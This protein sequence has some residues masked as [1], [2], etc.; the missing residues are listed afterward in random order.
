MFCLNFQLKSTE[1]H[2][3]GALAEQLRMYCIEQVKSMQACAK[4]FLNSSESPDRHIEMT[5]EMAHPILWTVDQNLLYWPAKCL[6]VNDSKAIV[7]FFGN[8]KT[9]TVDVKDCWLYSREPPT[10][11]SD[12][13]QL[14]ARNFS[15]ALEVRVEANE[16]ANSGGLRLNLIIKIH[17][18]G[19][20]WRKM[21]KID[22]K[23]R[24][25]FH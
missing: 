16:S 3:M 24:F 25:S 15:K 18:L 7:Q 20:C 8:H 6:A 1:D 14:D 17:I 12:G 19:F 13:F 22:R 5:C 11:K 21:F 2:K 9:A 10:R 4:C 23:D